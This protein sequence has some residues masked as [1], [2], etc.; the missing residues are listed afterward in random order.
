MTTMR[1]CRVCGKTYA[2]R[3]R[4][5]RPEQCSVPCRLLFESR[6][7]NSPRPAIGSPCWIW[8]G[9]VDRKGY[10]RISVDSR[11]QFVHRVAWRVAFGPIA[12]GLGVLHRCDNPPCFNPS[13]MFLGTDADNVRDMI[14]K[15][16]NGQPKGAAHPRARLAEEDVR[17]IRDAYDEGVSPAAMALLYDVSRSTISHIVLRRK[18]LH[19]V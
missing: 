5:P 13:H 7:E 8:I 9:G 11:R 15:G 1:E 18:W 3:A 16:R 6:L 12:P 14:A 2:P 10:G 19:V 4:Q 17:L